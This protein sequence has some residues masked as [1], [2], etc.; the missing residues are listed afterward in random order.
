MPLRAKRPCAGRCGR[1]VEKGYCIACANRGKG[2]TA[3]KSSSQRGYDGKWRKY[4]LLFLAEHPFCV[5]PYGTHGL[6]EVIATV[7]DHIIPHRGNMRLF[8]SPKNHQPLCETCHN[9][10]TATEDGGFGH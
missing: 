3:R 6:I 10:K 2:V 1:L 4:R 9:T 7:V 8:W 5:D